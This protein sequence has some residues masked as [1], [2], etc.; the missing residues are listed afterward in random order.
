MK[1]IAPVKEA[2]EPKPFKE[3]KEKQPRQPKEKPFKERPVK[4]KPAKEK[5]PKEPREEKP[6]Q[7]KP[8]EIITDPAEIKEETFEQYL[9][10]K[11]IPDPDL[12]IRTSGELRLSN[13]LL[14][15]LAYT[16]FYFTDVPWPAFTKEELIKAIE[17]YN[18]R[19]RRFGGVEE[20]K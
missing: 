10:T 3:P 15:Q 8:V 13:Y 17:E 9:D 4:E 7:S 5:L 6:K 16:E 11:G 14:W 2:K 1:E 20:E 12:M 18:H 19:H